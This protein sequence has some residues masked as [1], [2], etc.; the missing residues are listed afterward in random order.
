MAEEEK[1][2]TNRGK[3]IWAEGKKSDDRDDNKREVEEGRLGLSVNECG[4]GCEGGIREHD[5]KQPRYFQQNLGYLS[6][7]L[8]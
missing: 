5:L 6:I 4:C 3:V 7:Y 2:K 1:K 8:R